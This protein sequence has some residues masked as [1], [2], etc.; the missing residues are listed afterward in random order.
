[1]TSEFL[2]HFHQ[3]AFIHAR[4]DRSKCQIHKVELSWQESVTLIR[5]H[6]IFLIHCSEDTTHCWEVQRN[7][8]RWR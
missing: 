2:S 8:E 5:K 3:Q 7:S 1:M 6:T 4:E